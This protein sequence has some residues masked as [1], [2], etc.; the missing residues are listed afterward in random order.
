MIWCTVDIIKFRRQW[1]ELTGPALD[2]DEYM[3]MTESRAY[4]MSYFPDSDNTGGLFMR[5]GAGR[6]C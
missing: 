2:Q 1:M 6:K 4:K 3:Y 5:I